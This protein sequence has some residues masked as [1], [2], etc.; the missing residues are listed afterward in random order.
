MNRFEKSKIGADIFIN[1]DIKAKEKLQ[2][3]RDKDSG[4]G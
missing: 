1:A 2:K 3:H 4:R